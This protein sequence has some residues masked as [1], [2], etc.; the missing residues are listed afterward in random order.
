M[1]GVAVV[2]PLHQ[3]AALAAPQHLLCQRPQLRLALQSPHTRL[4]HVHGHQGC[5]QRRRKHC[6]DMAEQ[7]QSTTSA[8]CP[9]AAVQP[10]ACPVERP[11]NAIKIESCV[12]M[13]GGL[14]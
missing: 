4:M 11:S 3:V 2:P 9:P 14:S 5:G 13:M 6:G 1:E 12:L 7:L 8:C 10:H